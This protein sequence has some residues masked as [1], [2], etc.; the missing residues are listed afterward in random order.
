MNRVRD[1]L[2]YTP[3]LM[4]KCHCRKTPQLWRVDWVNER[5]VESEWYVKC[6]DDCDA[7]PALM[8]RKTVKEAVDLWNEIRGEKDEKR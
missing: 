7:S 1:T 3:L 5:K 4:R 8:E 6:V 2:D